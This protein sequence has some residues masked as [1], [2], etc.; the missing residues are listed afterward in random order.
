MKSLFKNAILAA[1]LVF[2]AASISN[3]QVK[4]G[5]NPASI[6]TTSNLEVEAT[7]G[8]KTIVNKTTGQVTIQD[9]TQAVDKVLTSD[10]SG[11]AS[12]KSFG[13]SKVPTMVMV[14]TI[15]SQTS[16][17]TSTTGGAISS[18]LPFVPNASYAA[19]WDA[20]NRE[21]IVPVSGFYRT[22]LSAAFSTSTASS[23]YIILSLKSK[24]NVSENVAFYTNNIGARTL[25]ETAYYN[26][27]DRI[28]AFVWQTNTGVGIV[29]SANFAI[30]YIP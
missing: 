15:T 23:G 21:Y 28:F 8:N 26:A 27:G 3:A 18:R 29:Y 24:L 4:V 16:L 1:A 22:D 19:G 25:S 14:G 11:N 12:W 2:G 9:G 30:T 17:G 6:G 7:N 10:A 5:A 20:T 13:E